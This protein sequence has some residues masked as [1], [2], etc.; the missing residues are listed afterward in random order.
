MLHPV[1]FAKS[2]GASALVLA[3]LTII[4]PEWFFQ[5][6]D[7]EIQEEGILISRL[8][9]LLALG[10]GLAVIAITK[11]EQFTPWDCTANAI[12]DAAAFILLVVAVQMS[13]MN[14][15]G[16]LLALG[17]ASNAFGFYNWRRYLL[18]EE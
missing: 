8:Y 13:V 1:S 9:G 5:L 16:Y 4:F 3:T 12:A 6:L 10:G 14:W 15:V 17:Y 11:P 18:A 2:K 7:V